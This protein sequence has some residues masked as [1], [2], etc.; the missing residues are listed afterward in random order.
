[1]A[2]THPDLLSAL[3]VTGGSRP[4]AE[5]A[6]DAAV[7]VDSSVAGE[8]AGDGS[9]AAA[10]AAP[11]RKRRPPAKK[12]ASTPAERGSGTPRKSTAAKTAPPAKSTARSTTSG[13]GRAAAPV[14]QDD[15]PLV[16]I[17]TT[18]DA[19]RVGLYLHKDDYRAL[20][21]A[22]LD[23]GFDMNARVRAMIAIYRH[24]PRFRSLVD[25][26]A[27]NAPRGG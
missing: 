21:L 10:V 11:A 23:D 19:Q 5:P 25:R 27:R 22:K 8:L 12:A 6:A 17:P 14:D 26:T 3:N 15:E 7:A 16:L 2:K 24:N 1:M 18:D 9:D 20:N 13:R 4:D